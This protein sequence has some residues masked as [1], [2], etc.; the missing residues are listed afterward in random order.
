MDREILWELLEKRCKDDSEK[1]IVTLLTRLH[2]ESII[3]VGEHEI[4]AEMGLP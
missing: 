1:M 3:Q 4:N 2:R